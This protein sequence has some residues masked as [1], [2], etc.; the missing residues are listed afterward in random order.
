MRKGQQYEDAWNSTSIELVAA[1]EMHG[2]TIIVETFYNTV[3]KLNG[4]VSSQLGSVLEQLLELYAVNTA[5]R[6]SGDLLRVNY[7]FFFIV[8][9]GKFALIHSFKLSF[10]NEVK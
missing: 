9:V 2:R 5:L 8:T 1:A 7:F 6:C 4:C 10:L 3:K